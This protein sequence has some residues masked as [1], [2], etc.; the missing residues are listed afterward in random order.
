MTMI[1][2]DDVPVIFEGRPR[3]RWDSA[4]AGHRMTH[5]HQ[6]GAGPV[7]GSLWPDNTTRTMLRRRLQQLGPTLVVFDIDAADVVLPAIRV[8]SI[9]DG[10]TTRV[11]SDGQL[12]MIVQPLN[13]LDPITRD[14]GLAFLEDVRTTA[15]SITGADD[16]FVEDD[17]VGSQ[18]PLRFVGHRGPL[19]LDQLRRTMDHLFRSGRA[20]ITGWTSASRP[21]PILARAA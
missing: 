13:W 1:W 5:D 21:A 19:G 16:P 10:A 4:H 15:P 7:V 12:T 3:I 11:R 17:L 2:L 14:R 8:P 6:E 9:P 20:Q 18:E